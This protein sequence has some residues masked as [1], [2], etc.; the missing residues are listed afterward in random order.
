MALLRLTGLPVLGRENGKSI[1]PV[2][3]ERRYWPVFQLGTSQC[4]RLSLTKAKSSVGTVDQWA[5]KLT[6]RVAWSHMREKPP[7]SMI[8]AWENKHS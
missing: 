3:R 7:L 6:H 8:W 4:E 5:P 1:L 2:Y